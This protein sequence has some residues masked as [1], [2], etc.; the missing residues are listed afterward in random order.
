MGLAYSRDSS[1]DRL[2]SILEEQVQKEIALK[3]L[4]FE[5]TEAFKVSSTLFV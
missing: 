5:Q 3:N 1:V 2:A 4:Q